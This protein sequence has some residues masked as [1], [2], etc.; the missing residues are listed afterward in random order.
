MTIENLTK[1]HLQM[2]LPVPLRLVKLDVKAVTRVTLAVG[3]F[4]VIPLDSALVERFCWWGRWGTH[5]M[6]L[7]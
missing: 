2:S 7:A 5:K 3:D 4:V 1:A 6:I